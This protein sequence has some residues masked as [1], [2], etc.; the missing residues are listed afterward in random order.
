MLRATPRSFLAH[1]GRLLPSAP[2]DR[3]IAMDADFAEEH[4]VRMGSTLPV[5]FPGDRST[6]PTVAALTDVEGGEGF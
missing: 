6:E 2:A 1:K 4:G 3:S 5:E